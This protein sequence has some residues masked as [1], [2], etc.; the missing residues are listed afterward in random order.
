[1]VLLSART[2]WRSFEGH[3]FKNVIA[4]GI[5]L[6]EDG[7]KMSK[8]LQNYP[9]PQE[10]IDAYGADAVRLYLLTSPVVRAENL[11]FAESGVQQ[12]SSKVMGRLTNI[13][14]FYEQYK[15]TVAHEL[16]NESKN[17][18]DAWIVARMQQVHGEVTKAMDAYE[19]DRASRP[20]IDFVDD[21][22]TWY[23][24][25]SRDRFKGDDTDDKKAALQTIAWV[26]HTYAKVCAPFTPFIADWLWMRVRREND[27]ESVHLA[28]WD[29]VAD[30]VN[31]D[32]LEQMQQV[33]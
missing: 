15:D 24:R 2:W 23:I 19:L 14:S 25:R 29:T 6:A 8:R 1:M 28:Q 27:A 3:V 21:F 11:N 5:V 12:L 7:K 31:T 20:L 13:Y 30:A 4:N 9:D 32:V 18:L 26:L 33:Q 17:V 10:V 22:S 16:S